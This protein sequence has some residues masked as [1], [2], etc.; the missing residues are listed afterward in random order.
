[1]HFNNIEGGDVASLGGALGANCARLQTLELQ[2]NKIRDKG[3]ADLARALAGSSG[4]LQVLEVLNLRNNEIGDTGA[5]SL[6]KAFEENRARL[7]T[8]N[9]SYNRIADEGAQGVAQ[10]L[11]TC[12]DVTSL[13]MSVNSIGTLGLRALS[14]ALGPCRGLLHAN[15]ASNM[16]Y[17][18]H[19]DDEEQ[20]DVL[21]VAASAHPAHL[22]Q[23]TI[24][25]TALCFHSMQ[26]V[27]HQHSRT[28]V[29]LDLTNT[30]FGLRDARA[31]ALA[32]QGN[33]T[34]QTLDL[35]DNNTLNDECV[36][37]LALQLPS[38]SSLRRL[39]LEGCVMA[40]RG[41][42]HL[43]LAMPRCSA[44]T[45]LDLSENRV[46]PHGATA[47]AGALHACPALAHLRLEHCS[48]QTAGRRTL[49]FAEHA[50]PALRVHFC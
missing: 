43:A 28:L 27:V 50:C 44:L 18:D 37:V 48:L 11:G 4:W 36:G 23:L 47:L 2:H 16:R 14:A 46:G 24:A 12:T 25:N 31:L 33:A 8:L 5:A 1:M 30:S 17:V 45:D 40:E 9:L 22:R 49:L 38:A 39:N 13:V 6:A 26:N 42:E 20:A 19:Q 29:Y 10:A 41:C 3:A 21:P 15:L 35:S 32:L 7:R 34:L